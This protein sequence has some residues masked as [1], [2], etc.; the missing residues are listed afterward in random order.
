MIGVLILSGA[1]AG[2]APAA[3]PVSPASEVTAA[4]ADAKRLPAEIAY[5]TRYLS[6]LA[7]PGPDR[8]EFVKV[9]SFWSNSLSREAELVKPRRIGDTLLAVVLDEF[10]WSDETWEKLQETDPYFHVRLNIS[11]GGDYLFFHRGGS[12]GSYTLAAGWYRET[13]TAKAIQVSAL[14]PWL[15]AKEARELSLLTLSACPIVRADWWLYQTA[16][17]QDRKGTGYYDWL[18]LG[19]KEADFQ[20]LIGADVEA[21]KRVKKEIAAVVARSGVTLNN[22][23]IERLQAITGGYWRTSDYAT[24]KDKQNTL[25][26][27]DGS[28]EPPAGDASEQYGTLPNGLFAFWLQNA[29]GERVDVA[30]DF[31]ASDGQ[32]PDTDRRVHVGLS[33]VRCHAEGIRPIR[34]WM[35]EVYRDNLRLVS[36]DY[37]KLKRLRQLYLSDLER[38]IKRDQSDYAETLL[39]LNGLTPAANAKAFAAAHHRYAGEDRGVEEVA[40][41]CGVT[42]AKLTEALK[43]YAAAQPLDPVLAGL[44]LNPP[45]SIRAEHFEEIFPVL[46]GILRE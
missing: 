1:I 46:M 2:Q 17:Q 3:P 33:C 26:L 45:V 6:M 20:K 31:I 27:L 25:R 37:A 21:S 29:K 35:R 23:A 5:R 11:V 40:R 9:F 19:K 4:L 22:R 10:G 28:T 41:E 39:A 36:P 38:S 30:P 12:Y 13:A 15:P 16:Q 7:V 34:D 8:A 18:G 32:A 43:A 42:A 44:L 14:A 24:S